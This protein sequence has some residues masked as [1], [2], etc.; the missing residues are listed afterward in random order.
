[1]HTSQTVEPVHKR[2]AVLKGDNDRATD[3]GTET[4]PDEYD[5]DDSIVDH[6][7]FD[8]LLE[9]DD[10]EHK[11]TRGLVWRYFDQAEKIFNDM[12]SAV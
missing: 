8:Q 9:L 4:D 1:M 6:T 10:D 2:T 7:T 11:F 3:S 5:I 12:E